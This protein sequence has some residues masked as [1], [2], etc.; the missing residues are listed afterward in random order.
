MVNTISLALLA[1]AVL[2]ASAVQIDFRRFSTNKCE[3]A[4]HIR[5]DTNL[6][7]PHCKT[8]SDNEPPFS[9]FI[10]TG[11]D[12]M[13]DADKKH[14]YATVFDEKDC[15]GTATTFNRESFSHF[16]RLTLTASRVELHGP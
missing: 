5:K 6:H 11:D 2:S 1:S 7:D 3:D 8:F 14:C 4:Y 12:D 10:L 9:S 16:S 13:D 15:K